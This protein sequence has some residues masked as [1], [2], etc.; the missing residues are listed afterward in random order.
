VIAYTWAHF[1]NYTSDPYWILQLPMTKA[2]V[3][4]M[5]TAV[6]F[7]KARATITKYIPY[8]GSKRGWV[9]WTAGLVDTR[10]SAIAPIVMDF[11]N[12]QPSMHHMWRAYGGWTWTF[13]DYW[14]EGITKTIDDPENDLLAEIVDVYY[15]LPDPT[16]LT[17]PKLVISGTNDQFFMN[18]NDYYWWSQMREPKFR[19]MCANGDHS[20]S[21]NIGPIMDSTISFI[22]LFFKQSL[23]PSI[24][25]S[26]T[27]TAL[28][29][30]ITV[31]ND[32]SKW[33]PVKVS[34]WSAPS[35]NPGTNVTLLRDWRESGGYPPV[36]Q[37]PLWKET[38]LQESSPGT[39]IY[40]ATR[41]IP[42]VGWE[43]FFVELQYPVD[44]RNL[45]LT[46]QVYQMP[47]EIWPYDDCYGEGCYGT[48]V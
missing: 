23:F 29:G 2:V 13:K 41:P 30:I 22:N 37:N 7:W 28:E 45:R 3:R 34:M 36:T 8:G 15:Y 12:I 10:V 44:N 35:W 16:R 25:W 32:N 14:E 17:M 9:T 11:L 47:Q 43:G 31:V 4:A 20:L 21:N 1:L 38:S 6:D 5:D 18:D 24:T 33:I 40:V 19:M 26:F 42:D 27:Q 48:L 39:G 46:T